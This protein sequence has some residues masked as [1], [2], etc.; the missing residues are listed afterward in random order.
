MRTIEE[1]IGIG[2]VFIFLVIIFLIIEKLFPGIPRQKFMRRGF[3]TDVFYW[4]FTPTVTKLITKITLAIV[5][6]II[7]SILG[8]S[9]QEIS[10]RESTGFG[11]LSLQPVWMQGIQVFLLAD[12]LSYWIHRIFHNKSLWKFHAVHH[13][14][15][16]LDWL[17]S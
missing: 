12:F 3:W 14:S 5:F 9:W 1:I 15:T 11:I 2:I 10:D 13:S 16:E 17:S 6:I 8:I 7:A 4:F